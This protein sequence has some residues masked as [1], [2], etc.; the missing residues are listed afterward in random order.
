MNFKKRKPNDRPNAH[1]SPG[2][3]R[4]CHSSRRHIPA[5]SP[6][7][8]RVVG[9]EGEVSIDVNFICN[10][11]RVHMD[12]GEDIFCEPCWTALKEEHQTENGNLLDYI[13]ELEKRI[14]ELEGEI[15]AKT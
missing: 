1:G 9:E 13:T 2:S 8:G 12:N 4:R 10:S 15:E 5:H 11:C 14:T 6:K 3:R 7:G